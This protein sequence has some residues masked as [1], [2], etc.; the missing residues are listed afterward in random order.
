M[1]L[2]NFKMKN[3]IPSPILVPLIRII[4][5]IKVF[6]LIELSNQNKVYA[7]K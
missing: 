4:I 6:S 7:R 2:N 1:G 5:N 3:H